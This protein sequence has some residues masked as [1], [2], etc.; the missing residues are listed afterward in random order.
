M[1]KYPPGPDSTNWNKI[2]KAINDKCRNMK[3]RNRMWIWT[4]NVDSLDF[5]P[6]QLISLQSRILYITYHKFSQVQTSWATPLVHLI[7]LPYNISYITYQFSGKVH[8]CGWLWQCFSIDYRA[9]CAY[10]ISIIDGFSTR[11]LDVNND[12]ASAMCIE[13]GRDLGRSTLR[14]AH[15][16]TSL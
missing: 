3:R 9:T 16:M 10:I 2:V 15:Y 4:D 6:V 12:N 14:L 8:E 11:E 7:L 13:T 5:P 1:Y